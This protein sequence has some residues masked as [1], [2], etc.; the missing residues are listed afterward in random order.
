MRYNRIYDC[1]LSEGDGFRVALFLQGCDI[2]CEGCFNKCAWDYSK[3]KEFTDEVVYKILRALESD[4]IRGLSILGGEPLSDCNL[5]ELR[6][7]IHLVRTTYPDK[8]IWLWTGHH[9]EDLSTEQLQC[10]DEVDTVISEPFSFKD[11]DRSLRYAGS[12]NQR[13]WS[14]SHINEW[15]E[16]DM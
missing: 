1:S 4:F 6:K 13:M 5:V 7:F 8:E 12:R 14:H 16:V 11:R 15:E 10:L 3:G 9:F 2:H